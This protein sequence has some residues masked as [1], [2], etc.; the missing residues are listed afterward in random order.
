MRWSSGSDLRPDFVLKPGVSA[1]VFEEF[2][3][4]HCLWLLIVGRG[5]Q[6]FRLDEFPRG[7]IGSGEPGEVGQLRADLGVKNEIDEFL[8]QLAAR[9]FRSTAGLS[10][11]I[12]LRTL[13]MK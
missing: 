1:E 2:Q 12:W 10:S 9:R 13:G 11:L 6:T 8:G 3:F 5:V 4:G 7:V